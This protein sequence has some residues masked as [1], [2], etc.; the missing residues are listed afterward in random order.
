MDDVCAP[1]GCECQLVRKRLQ[2]SRIRGSN[3]DSNRSPNQTHHLI[4][5][6]KVSLHYAS[7]PIA[8]RGFARRAVARC[9]RA[10]SRAV[11]GA[12][13]TVRTLYGLSTHRWLGCFD[14][15]ELAV[16]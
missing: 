2:K 13:L 8:V 1:T 14:T 6:I 12:P 3:S 10:R 16:G 7:P 5:S 9:D 11:F 15:A 4:A